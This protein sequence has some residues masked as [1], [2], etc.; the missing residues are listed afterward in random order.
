MCVCRGNGRVNRGRTR[1]RRGQAGTGGRGRLTFHP[2]QPEPRSR[3]GGGIG[4][5]T[6]K[7]R[8]ET[9]R[10]QGLCSG[11]STGNAP[12][13]GTSPRVPGDSSS[14]SGAA[15]SSG[16]PQAPGRTPARMRQERHR[17]R[18][19]M[20]ARRSPASPRR[21]S[22]H[23]PQPLHED[24]LV[25]AAVQVTPLE[26]SPQ[27]DDSQL[28]QSP[29]FRFRTKGRGPTKGCEIPQSSR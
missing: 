10:R 1:G 19:R 3:A 23:L 26:L 13:P 15:L 20:A 22:P 28:A 7:R 24:A 2:A 12:G 21:A 25:A 14:G 29:G 6:S 9:A 27:V 11:G 16:Q 5:Q 8:G 18:T 17:Q 4:A